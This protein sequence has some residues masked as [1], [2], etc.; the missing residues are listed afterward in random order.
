MP[1]LERDDVPEPIRGLT[2]E[3][4]LAVEADLVDSIAARSA[5]P[6]TDAV[7]LRG[8]A[9][10]DPAQ[11]RVV[12]ALAGDA[13]LLV[14]EGAAGSG[15]T[16]TLAAARYVLDLAD[17]RLAVVTPTLKAAQAAQQQA[18]TDAFSAAWLVHHHG[19]R[20]DE[21]GHWSQTDAAPEARAA[22]SPATSSSLT[23]PACSTK[24]PLARSSPSPTERTQ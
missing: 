15:K 19:Y 5:R 14:I 9:H 22:C 6:V 16:T 8:V 10:L 4:V 18:G 17:R 12:A 24:T 7:W 20:W 21:D 11:R 2:S 13:G 1:L 23:R 3:R